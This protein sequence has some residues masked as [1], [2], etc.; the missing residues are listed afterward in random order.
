MGELLGWIAEL[1]SDPGQLAGLSAELADLL[2]KLPPEFKEGAGA[3]TL[4]RPEQMGEIL[5]QVEQML[6]HQLHSSEGTA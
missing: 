1:R 6:V 5:D 3:L 2:D 4:D